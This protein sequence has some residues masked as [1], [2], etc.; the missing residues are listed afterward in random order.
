MEKF[1]QCFFF[2]FFFF[3]FVI[4]IVQNTNIYICSYTI[5]CEHINMEIV[6]TASTNFTLLERRGEG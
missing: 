4:N 3:F 5:Q 2:F 6:R 1:P